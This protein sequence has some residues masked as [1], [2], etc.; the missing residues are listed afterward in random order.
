M[1][2][3][4]TFIKNWF[5]KFLIKS[6]IRKSINENTFLPKK[7]KQKQ[8]NK[9]YLIMLTVLTQKNNIP[10]QWPNTSGEQPQREVEIQ[11]LN[12]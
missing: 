9:Y 10:E 11:I 2:N 6:R 7:V 4:T 1:Y 12:V 3:H 8:K 5:N